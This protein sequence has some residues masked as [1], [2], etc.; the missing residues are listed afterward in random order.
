MGLGS[1]WSDIWELGRNATSSP[2]PHLLNRAPPQALR[3]SGAQTGELLLRT[4]RC[5]LKNTVTENSR[6]PGFVG[7]QTPGHSWFSEGTSMPFVQGMKVWLCLRCAQCSWVPATGLDAWHDVP[8][9]WVPYYTHFTDG[10]TKVKEEILFWPV[11]FS[12]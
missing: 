8:A 5:C 1:S 4:R 11:W 10:N 9:R 3:G 7:T 6:N 2:R 12:G